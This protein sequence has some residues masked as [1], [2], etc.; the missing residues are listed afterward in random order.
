MS[1]KLGFNKSN[2]ALFSVFRNLIFGKWF[3]KVKSLRKHVL[4]EKI[5][6]SKSADA[7]LI[8]ISKMFTIFL[9]ILF[10]FFAETNTTQALP[11]RQDIVFLG[12]SDSGRR[13]I[14]SDGDHIMFGIFS[15]KPHQVSCMD[16]Y[17]DKSKYK[18]IVNLIYEQGRIDQTLISQANNAKEKP[19][20][21][22]PG[23]LAIVHQDNHDIALA[24][25]PEN[26][27][28]EID[29]LL[30]VSAKVCR[31][32]GPLPRNDLRDRL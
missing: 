30:G 9:G 25:I 6:N 12:N 28:N 13:D 31:V 1:G 23:L 32:L 29:K 16:F 3:F 15:G 26:R 7:A 24:L 19:K 27:L 17:V 2:G 22:G 8:N 20:V 11:Q 18:I 10:L 14:I 4:K 21:P 5:C